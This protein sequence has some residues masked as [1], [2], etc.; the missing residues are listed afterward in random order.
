M[1]MADYTTD[2]NR[3][4]HGNLVYVWDS[5][6]FKLQKIISKIF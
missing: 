1:L 3:G 6:W 4:I 2:L 5:V